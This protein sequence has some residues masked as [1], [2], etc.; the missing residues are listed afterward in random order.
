VQICYERAESLCH[1]LNR[2]L[3]LYVALVGQWRYL[4]MTDTLTATLQVA[5]RVYSLAQEQND[6][7]LMMGACRPLSCTSYFLG[8]FE[9]VR[10]Y[11][12]RALQI[13]HSGGVQSPVEEVDTP[14]VACLCDKAQSE[15]HFGEI[16]ASHATM[17]EAIA[18]A[19]ELNDMH[20]LAS[21]LYFAAS[22][23]NLGVVLLK[24]TAWHQMSLNCQLVTILRIGWLQ[25]PYSAVG[26]AA[27]PVKQ[28][29]ASRGLSTVSET[30]GPPAR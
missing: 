1:S 25:D 19:K 12:M 17:A 14:I 13:W 30:F 21:T 10:R 15:W 23:C 6:S 27:L 28:M 26:R 22:I 20:G 11:T 4:L 2:P 9:S 29:K 3:F 18:L 7:A 8:D 16:D 5:K 24:W